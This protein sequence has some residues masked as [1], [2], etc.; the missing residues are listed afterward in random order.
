MGHT[1]RGIR[2]GSR[3]T[4]IG[5]LGGLG[6]GKGNKTAKQFWHLGLL[7]GEDG[8]V[9]FATA[10]TRDRVMAESASLGFVVEPVDG[11][12]TFGFRPV[13]EFRPRGK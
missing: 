5:S 6:L 10:S 8:I 4:G 12:E 11:G 13:D 1:I 7:V 2:Q 9:K 3:P